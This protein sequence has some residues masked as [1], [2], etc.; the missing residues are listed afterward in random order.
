MIPDQYICNPGLFLKSTNAYVH[1]VKHADS[2]SMDG[3]GVLDLKI[4][5]S[6]DLSEQEME[7]PE[8]LEAPWSCKKFSLWYFLN[9]IRKIRNIIP[10][11]LKIIKN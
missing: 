1:T 7:N 2:G 11:T 4:K 10:I 5:C 3:L 9:T 8:K 6:D